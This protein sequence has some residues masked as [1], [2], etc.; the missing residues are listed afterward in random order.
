MSTKVA[1]SFINGE[2][3]SGDRNESDIISPYTREK[4]GAKYTATEEDAERT[5][6]A[7]YQSKKEITQITAYE[8][9]K[10]LKNAAS[11]LEERKASF[12]KLISTELGKPLK[13]TLDEVDRSIET[14]ELSGEE[15]KRLVG[16]TI[17]WIFNTRG[18]NS[19]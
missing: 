3:L 10:R 16:E 15:A 4:I 9:A 12:A 18:A 8:R 17:H 19:Y 6:K 2:W 11:L 14:L 5:L 1:K 7:A 13:N